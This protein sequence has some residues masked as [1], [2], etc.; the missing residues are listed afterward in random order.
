MKILWKDLYQEAE[1]YKAAI[2]LYTKPLF[3]WRKALSTSTDDRTLYDFARKGLKN[4][5]RLHESLLKQQFQFRPGRALHFNFNGRHRTLYIFPWEERLVDL[6]LYRLLNRRMHKWFSPHAYAYRSGGLFGVDACQSRIGER[7]VPKDKP[8]FLIK[9][10]IRDYFN[11]IRHDVLLQQVAAWVPEEDYLFQ[12]L[13]QRIGFAYEDRGT[14]QS[15]VR[16]IPFGTAI[17]CW[18]A[19]LHLTGMDHELAAVPGLHY[20]RYADDILAAAQS[21]ELALKAEEILGSHFTRLGLESKASHEKNLLFSETRREE[22]GFTWTDR[23]KHLGLEFRANGVT[24]LSRDKFRK[25]RNLFRYAFRRKKGKFKRMKDPLQKAGL[26]IQLARETLDD[27]LRN[28]AIIDYYLKHVRDEEQI[29]RIDRWL[30]EEVL[31]LAFGGGHKKGYFKRLSFKRLR[32]MGLPSLAH[33]RR[34]ILHR[35]IESPFFIWK[36]YKQQKGFKGTAVR[37]SGSNREAFSPVPEAAVQENLVGERDRLSMGVM[38]ARIAKAIRSV[39]E[40]VPLNPL[41]QGN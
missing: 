15:A 26:A 28:V 35:Q 21:K 37:P 9:R 8:Y 23:F 30:A 27:G 32:A 10:D 19:N 6:L 12:L 36:S 33:R 20:Y 13:Q 2:R 17:A 16:G 40:A 18:F 11:S 22:A 3:S 25:I 31:S 1:L 38:E 39:D 4:L 24:G 29:A 14:V 5:G 41:S 7:L 34:L